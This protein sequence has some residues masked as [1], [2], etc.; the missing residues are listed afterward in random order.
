MTSVMR[1]RSPGVRIE[2]NVMGSR[3]GSDT[4]Y[5]LGSLRT[6]SPCGFAG[7]GVLL[8]A[9]IRPV[10]SPGRYNNIL[11]FLCAIYIFFARLLACSLARKHTTIR[12]FSVHSKIFRSVKFSVLSFYPIFFYEKVRTVA[13]EGPSAPFQ[14]SCLQC[15]HVSASSIMEPPHLG[16]Y[17]TEISHKY[18]ESCP[19]YFGFVSRF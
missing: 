7:G 3:T 6:N 18:F 12:E 4:Q 15:G 1:G 9:K 11:S 2:R 14:F 19:L 13:G 17:L 5:L 16:G 10:R 8:L